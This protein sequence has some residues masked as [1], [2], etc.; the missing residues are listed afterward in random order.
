MASVHEIRPPILSGTSEP[1]PIFD[2]TTR[3]YITYSCP[4]AQRGL[5]EKIKL[6][7][8]DLQNMPSWYKEKVHPEGKVPSLEH[9][10]KI[11]VESIDLIKYIDANFEGPSLY[12][13]DPAKKE[14][15]EELIKYVDT[16]TKD[17]FGSFK[18]D[19]VT[20]TSSAYDYLENALGKY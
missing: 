10:G 18:G 11:L 5:Q 8:F 15:G 17:T 3:L 14:F 20:K 12:P 16:F 9:D 2:G 1:P 4:F 6:V 7:P 19:P 13:N